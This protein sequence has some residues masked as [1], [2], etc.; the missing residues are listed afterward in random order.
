MNYKMLQSGLF[1]PIYPISRRHI[2]WHCNIKKCQ[3]MIKLA[4]ITCLVFP[5]AAI[6]FSFVSSSWDKTRLKLKLAF[7]EPS[8][9][10]F[11]NNP[12]TNRS[13]TLSQGKSLSWKVTGRWNI[14]NQMCAIQGNTF[15]QQSWTTIKSLRKPLKNIQHMHNYEAA[16]KAKRR[17]NILSCNIIQNLAFVRIK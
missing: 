15:L 17:I 14:N 16:F 2:S 9:Q 5:Q 12:S 6:E 10:Y 3:M 11:R 8:A 4:T 1:S 7:S 13:A